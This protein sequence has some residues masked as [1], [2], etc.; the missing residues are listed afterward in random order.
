[1]PIVP[2]Y[3]YLFKKKNIKMTRNHYKL[4]NNH[5]SCHNS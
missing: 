5:N 4:V 2:T 1:M 3:T